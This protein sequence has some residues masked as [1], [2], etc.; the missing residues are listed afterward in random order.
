VVRR[1]FARREPGVV[2]ASCASALQAVQTWKGERA[3]LTPASP[4]VQAVAGLTG[5][6]AAKVPRAFG[7]QRRH[8]DAAE[9]AGPGLLGGGLARDL[10]RNGP[11]SAPQGK[12]DR[13]L[14]DYSPYLDPQ[15]VRQ[16]AAE[17]VVTC[18]VK[19]WTRSRMG[20]DNGG[21]VGT[22]RRS[23]LSEAR[24]ARRGALAGHA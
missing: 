5:A 19:Y 13:V 3:R 8:P 22:R 17:Q 23:C 18:R 24:A 10:F 1:D 12:V 6:D 15:W 7:G 2:A 16:V 21:L 4:Q 20:N 14:V 9:Q 11:L